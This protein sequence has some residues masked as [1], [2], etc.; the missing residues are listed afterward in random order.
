MST[1][2]LSLIF[3]SYTY[4]LHLEDILKMLLLEFGTNPWLD[5]SDQDTTILIWLLVNNPNI[6][7]NAELE[8]DLDIVGIIL[9]L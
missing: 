9:K 2:L 6:S 1:W 4:I 7:E 8:E 5:R 3:Y